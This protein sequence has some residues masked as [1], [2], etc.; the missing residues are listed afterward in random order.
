[1]NVYSQCSWDRFIIIIITIINTLVMSWFFAPADVK[2]EEKTPE[3]KMDTKGW[4]LLVWFRMIW[5]IQYV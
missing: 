5:N 2:E 1:M 4:V 3:E